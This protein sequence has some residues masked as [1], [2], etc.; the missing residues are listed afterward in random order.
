MIKKQFRLLM[1]FMAL[2]FSLQ[3]AFGMEE[4]KS[5]A[6]HS[7]EE[8]DRAIKKQKCEFQ[9]FDE[10]PV[11]LLS[12]VFEIGLQDIIE[13]NSIFTP[14]DGAKEFLDTIALVCKQFHIFARDLGWKNCLVGQNTVPK[15]K[16]IVKTWFVPKEILTD[17]IGSLNMKL[18]HELKD[19]PNLVG[20]IPAG[21]IKEP[22]KKTEKRLKKI[23]FNCARYLI[24]GANPNLVIIGPMGSYSLAI[25]IFAIHFP[26]AHKL[27]PLLL[28]RNVN[29][30]CTDLDRETP[31]MRSR[32]YPEILRQ[33]LEYDKSSINALRICK[34]S[35]LGLA[36]RG[37]NI[38]SVKLLLQ[39]GAKLGNAL[40][41][42]IGEF[43]PS[44]ELRAHM[45]H[46][47]EMAIK[48]GLL[49]SIEIV[50]LLVEY[51]ADIESVK[52]EVL[53][54]HPIITREWLIE[55][56]NIQNLKKQIEP[57]NKQD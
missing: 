33:L 27:I 54:R 19:I 36:I 3:S 53:A 4:L 16:I 44:F 42:A 7:R 10:L 15:Y 8:S 46:Y 38:E 14:L 22:I 31:I 32:E 6:P 2:I 5:K 52:D 25:L 12:Y 1:I 24:A 48:E 43:S 13:G 23:R 47:N 41:D 51:G 11:E 35:A 39:H 26:V 45:P 20:E 37:K 34:K 18:M 56:R 55:T 21:V 29:S 30:N 28:L 40:A 17:Y 9:P 50:K 57:K 49:L